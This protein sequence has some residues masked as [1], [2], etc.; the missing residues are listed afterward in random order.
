MAAVKL[1]A[2][3]ATLSS[4]NAATGPPRDRYTLL[5]ARSLTASSAPVPGAAELS[6]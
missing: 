3:K 6:G 5:T 1:P 4:R 2:T